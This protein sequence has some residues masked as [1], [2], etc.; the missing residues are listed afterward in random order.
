MQGG[1]D[2]T[3]RPRFR[4]QKLCAAF[5]GKRRWSCDRDVASHARLTCGHRRR[6]DLRRVYPG[7]ASG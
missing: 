3:A 4:Q 5:V 7:T 1:G 6:L 2:Y